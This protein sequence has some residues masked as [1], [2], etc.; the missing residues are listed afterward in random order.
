MIGLSTFH[1][2]SQ[3]SRTTHKSYFRTD[4]LLS[5]SNN[6]QPFQNK[7]TDS[8]TRNLRPRVL[9]D[10]HSS[11]SSELLS[12]RMIFVNEAIAVAAGDVESWVS[13]MR[14][15]NAIVAAR[16]LMFWNED[17]P[18]FVFTESGTGISSRGDATVEALLSLELLGET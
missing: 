17:G 11:S 16:G 13:S 14:R 5:G 10:V 12:N 4:A 8:H 18:A 2:F 3:H 1:N 7:I 15:F 9:S 6:A